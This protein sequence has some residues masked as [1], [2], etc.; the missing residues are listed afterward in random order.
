MKQDPGRQQP[1]IPFLQG[2]EEVKSDL[3]TA[4][5][6]IRRIA[7]TFQGI[8]QVADALEDIG[9]IDQTIAERQKA[10]VSVTDE[11][12]SLM[13]RRDE[14]RA[15]VDQAKESARKILE[16]AADKRD[17]IISGA[18]SSADEAAKAIVATAN[19][20]AKDAMQRAEVER[21]RV[22]DEIAK[23]NL[24]AD[25]AT[26]QET[27]ALQRAMTANAAADDAEKRLDALKGK[28]KALLD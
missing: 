10:I 2:G 22:L 25:E 18:K 5:E 28:L 15:E 27:A 23:L 14:A 4:A 13:A 17:D 24:A 6:T 11:L 12:V 26:R 8:G 3:I 19:Q 20:Q 16:D 9:K 7:V 1:G 21:A